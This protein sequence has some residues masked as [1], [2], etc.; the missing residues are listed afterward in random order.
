[1]GDLLLRGVDDALKVELQKSARKNGRS[2]SE[3][4]I[5]SIRVALSLEP[6]QPQTAGSRLRA[7]VGDQSFS[8]E[9][10]EAIAAFRKESDRSP[11][12]FE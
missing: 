7:I 6:H 5:A 10:L 11:P 1:M 8:P 9:E 3:E 12:N 4:A 2:L